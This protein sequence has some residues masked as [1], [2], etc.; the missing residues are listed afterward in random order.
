MKGK[1]IDYL[2]LEYLSEPSFEQY[3]SKRIRCAWILANK[4]Y[5]QLSEDEK[6]QIIKKIN[7]GKKK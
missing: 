7:E 6:Q 2:T 5:S 4:K 1:I 3:S